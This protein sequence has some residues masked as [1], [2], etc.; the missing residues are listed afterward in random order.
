VV[1]EKWA[2]AAAVAA[3][4][5]GKAFAGLSAALDGL[6]AEPMDVVLLDPIPAGTPAQGQL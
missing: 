5:S 1:I 2:D 4:G 6:L 3:H